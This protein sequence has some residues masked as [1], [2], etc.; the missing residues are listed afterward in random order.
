MNQGKKVVL[1][2]KKS[3]FT[4]I[5][6]KAESLGFKILLKEEEYKDGVID[7]PSICSCGN[8]CNYKIND[9]IISDCYICNHGPCSYDEYKRYIEILGYKLNITEEQYSGKSK[10]YS[11]YCPENHPCSLLIYNLKKGKTSCVKC[12]R[13]KTK[14][15]NVE[16]YGV[17]NPMQNKEIKQKAMATNVER[18]GAANPMQNEEI[19]QKAMDTNVERYGVSNP[20][21]NEEIKQKAM[22]T[23]VERYGVSNPM[24]NEEIKQKAIETNVERYGV[25]SPM[26]NEEIKQKAMDTN[27]E[28]YG[29]S[30][31]MQNEEIKQ[32]AIETNRERYGCDYTLQ[33]EEVRQKAIETNRERYGCDYPMQNQEI[34]NKQRK[35][36]Y[37]AK[38]YILPSG[39]EIKIQGYEGFCLD[40]LFEQGY[41]EADLIIDIRFNNEN[42]IYDEMPEIWYEFENKKS[43]YFPDI[44][45]PKEK[46]IIEVKSDYYLNK[47]LDKNNLKA[48]KCIEMGYS[49]E[50][51]I[52]NRTGKL[53]DVVNM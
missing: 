32:K 44:F 2:I 46:R 18:Y 8:I 26:Q 52:Y 30:N 23:S 11:G 37:C 24:Q 4:I 7:F 51:R 50:F 53:I 15:T 13:M 22:N 5:K 40:E 34:S 3:N 48:K 39:K 45:I 19:K 17:S 47:H 27:V 10:R 43:R 25:A 20:M 28:R 21:Q 1:K 35:N 38:K 29:V 16:R 14:E 41:E 42:D 36:S 49:F 9:E 31:A 33:N 12:G 6:E